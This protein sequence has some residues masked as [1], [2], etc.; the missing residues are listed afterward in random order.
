[1]SARSVTFTQC[2]ASAALPSAAS[3]AGS[4]LLGFE[5]RAPDGTWHAATAKIDADTVL[6]T[7]DAVTDPQEARLGYADAFKASR[8]TGYEVMIYSC[9]HGDATLFSRGDLVEA[10]WRVAQ[11][12]LDYWKTSPVEFPNYSRG[13][14]GPTEADRLIEADGRE[15]RTL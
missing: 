10:A 5:V 8:Y 6:V 14:W 9:T 12:L 4:P 7:C 15:W 13:T 11:P 1:M 2:R 3:P